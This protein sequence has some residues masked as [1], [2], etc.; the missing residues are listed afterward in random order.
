MILKKGERWSFSKVAPK[1]PSSD[2]RFKKVYSNFG[3]NGILRLNYSHFQEMEDGLY[4]DG[5]EQC[6]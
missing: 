5:D 1:M 2:D 6:V 4:Y 3:Q